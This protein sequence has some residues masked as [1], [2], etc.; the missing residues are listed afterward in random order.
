M[1]EV[2][3]LGCNAMLRAAEKPSHSDREDPRNW[4]DV[5]TLI[6]AIA[7]MRLDI[8]DFQLFRGFRA[9]HRVY[10][11]D[12]KRRCMQR[13]LPIGFLGVGPGFVG[14]KRSADGLTVAV[15]LPE[16]EH[17]RRVD[18]AKKAVDLAAFMSAPLVRIFA[19]GIPEESEDADHLWAG[20]VT[21][22]REVADYGA[23]KEIFVG[24][25]NHPPAVAP[26]GDDILR[27]LREIDRE[28]VTFILDTGQWHGSPGASSNGL[29]DAKVDFYEFMEQTA[30]YATY[31]RAKIYKIDSGREEWIDYERVIGILRRANFNGN[32]SIVYEGRDNCCDDLEGIAMAASHLRGLL[33]ADSS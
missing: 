16:Y 25:H 22:F 9:S 3:K 6:D 18:E 4:V 5:E 8:I 1:F 19:G 31:V 20:V 14:M 10:L 29:E 2:I 13:G 21:S 17:R 33:R 26:V 24:L 30:P 11:G 27:L 7:A 12:I 23:Q 32:M 15:P 28:N